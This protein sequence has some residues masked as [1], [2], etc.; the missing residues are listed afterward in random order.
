V[1]G[2]INKPPVL[3]TKQSEGSLDMFKTMELYYW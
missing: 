2:T 3:L 1:N